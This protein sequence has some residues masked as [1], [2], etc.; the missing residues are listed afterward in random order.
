MRH[1]DDHGDE[2]VN[3][4]TLGIVCGHN[5]SSV[6]RTSAVITPQRLVVWL[7]FSV[8]LIDLVGRMELNLQVTFYQ[9]LEA[10]EVQVKKA[11]TL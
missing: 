1:N 4:E 6:S 3:E 10:C 11:L 9:I 8:L 2:D 5:P 7:V